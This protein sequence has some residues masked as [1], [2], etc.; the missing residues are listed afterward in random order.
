MVL[1]LLSSSFLSVCCFQ[2]AFPSCRRGRC[3]SSSS[4]N[5]SN[6]LALLQ[7]PDLDPEI[8]NSHSKAEE[9]RYEEEGLQGSHGD[10]VRGYFKRGQEI[11]VTILQFGPLGAS[12]IINDENIEAK[13]L[14]LQSEINYF[15]ERR[16]VNE[17]NDGDVLVGEI[18]P[19]YVERIREDGKVD[20]ALRPV[21]IT[22]IEIVGDMIMDALEGSPSGKIPIGDKTSPGD[23]GAY[24]HG[25]S[26]SDFKNAV[27]SL[28]RNGKVSPGKY[29]TTLIP[30]EERT[31]EN[32]EKNRISKKNAVLRASEDDQDDKNLRVSGDVS[33]IRVH[34]SVA[35]SDNKGKRLANLLQGPTGKSFRDRDESKTLFIGNLPFTVNEK[36]LKNTVD[37]VMGQDKVASI[38][39]VYDKQTQQPKGF[40]Y[41]EFYRDE[42]VQVALKKLKGVEVMGR[43]MRVDYSQPSNARVTPASKTIHTTSEID[44]PFRP[45]VSI[46][47]DR[48]IAL[49]EEYENHLQP[50]EDEDRSSGSGEEGKEGLEV[51]ELDDFFEDLDETNEGAPEVFTRTPSRDR[52]QR[53][54][55]GGNMRSFGE[56]LLRDNQQQQ[57]RRPAFA[58][59]NLPWSRAEGPPKFKNGQRSAATLFVGNL[60]YAVDERILKEEF[61][62]VLGRG[63]V[64][65]ARIA[66]EKGTQ[67]KRGF[68]YVDLWDRDIAEKAI[69][70]MHGK[71]SLMGRTINVDDAT[72]D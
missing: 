36:I 21:G 22:R 29:E 30:E 10:N 51:D 43:D 33:T 57:S 50:E 32:F 6:K 12:A 34:E 13:G 64:A 41:V 38:R 5:R 28:Y 67:R 53:P 35:G 27:G 47:Q 1:L 4:S 25:I 3:S 17:E 37:K 61:E 45:S 8:L 69:A 52:N 60:P 66:T 65:S 24:I 55:K 62:I 23:I 70:E 19:A 54:S 16:F 7:D 71:Y 15:R 46:P 63:T 72:R 44:R 11:E 31:P 40:G 39:L 59:D 58:D 9:P 48:A 42:D 2:R 49:S 14:I 68:G 56:K 26:K 20:I 18:I